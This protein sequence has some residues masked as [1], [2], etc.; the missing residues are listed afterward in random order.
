LTK[1][2]LLFCFCRK[3]KK[4]RKQKK[5]KEQPMQL[6]RQRLPKRLLKAVLP[7]HRLISLRKAMSF[8][9]DKRRVTL[10]TIT[11]KK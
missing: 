8:L 5:T 11:G 7:S 2:N 10:M 6:L 4:Q 1:I 3:Q 9:S